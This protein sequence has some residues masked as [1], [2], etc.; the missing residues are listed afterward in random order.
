MLFASLAMLVNILGEIC[1]IPVAKVGPRILLH[2]VYF[3]E[4]V[5]LETDRHQL[6]C[7]PR[8]ARAHCVTHVE[9]R[10]RL[11]AWHGGFPGECL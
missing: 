2:C 5:S 11:C 7:G 4:L 3:L 1:D 9:I 6:A 10:G 8:I